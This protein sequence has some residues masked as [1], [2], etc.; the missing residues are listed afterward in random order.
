M[1]ENKYLFTAVLGVVF[2][3]S[4]YNLYSYFSAQA[5][6]Q[7]ER[8]RL[9]K[10]EAM[11]KEVERARI[12][13]EKK[14]ETDR[15]EAEHLAVLEKEERQRA[16]DAAKLAEEKRLAQEAEAAAKQAEDAERLRIE[17]A[18]LQEAFARARVRE[19]IEDFSEDMITQIRSMSPRYIADHPEEF[20][21]IYDTQPGAHALGGGYGQ[22]LLFQDGTTALMIFA[23]V[24]QDTM[25][26]QALL[27]AGLDINAANKQG[28][29]AL[30]FAASYNLPEVIQFL[31]D[32]GAD[33][34]AKAYYQDVNA[35]HLASLLNPNPDAVET[36]IKAGFA[37]ETKTS[38][39]LTPLLLAAQE[40]LNLEVIERLA[41]L[42]ANKGTYDERGRNAKAVVEERIATRNPHFALISNEW[43]TNLVKF[44]GP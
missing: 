2:L 11:A 13:A 29:T 41:L 1:K 33:P 26:L 20:L 25:T 4:G 37:L 42:G 16:E 9:A 7:A 35:L 43:E 34:S 32:K 22:R 5:M 44:L 10:E 18:N 21:Q 15:K 30:M 17:N 39:G 12:V 27:D 6:Q 36:L 28:F 40:N 24:S 14:A 31:L 23:A 19:N 38:N 3:F 8:A